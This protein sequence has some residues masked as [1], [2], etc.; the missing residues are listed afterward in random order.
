MRARCNVRRCEKQV[1]WVET[2]EPQLAYLL[3]VNVPSRPTLPR[4][5]LVNEIEISC[6]DEKE[7]ALFEEGVQCG[8]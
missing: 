3:S 8:F 6:I 2:R 4:Q 5:V 1:L 7:K